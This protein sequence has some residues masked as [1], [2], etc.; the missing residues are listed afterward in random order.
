GRLELLVTDLL[1]R[2]SVP[3]IVCEDSGSG[4]GQR[5]T[6]RL[7]QLGYSNVSILDGGL[8]AW[9]KAGFETYS[10]VNVPSKAFGEF[11]EHE[12]GTPSMS[13]DELQRLIAEG[14]DLVVL[15]SRPFGE[16]NWA[17]IPGG[18]CCPGAELVYRASAAVPSSK[19]RVIVNCA[20]RTRSIIGAQSLINA[21]LPNE[22]YALRNGIMGWRLSGYEPVN[23][24]QA[25]APAPTERDKLDAKKSVTQVAARFAVQSISTRELSQ[26]QQERDSN[27]LFILDVRTI[28]EFDLNHLEGAVH[29]PGGQLVQA[30]DEYIGVRNARIVLVD[31]DATRATMTASWLTQMG[32]PNIRT[33]AIDDNPDLATVSGARTKPVVGLDNDRL[34]MIA[35]AVA[36]ALIDEGALVLDMSLSPT[37]REG[38]IPESWFVLRS[39]LQQCLA[40]IQASTPDFNTV[41]ALILTS[42]E[43][44]LAALGLSELRALTDK[45][46]YTLNGGNAAWQRSGLKLTST[47][48]KYGAE[49]IDIWRI[50]FIADKDKG[51]TV[52]DAMRAY[53]DWE[54]DL[55][56][57]LDRDAT[58][59]FQ[60]FPKA[61]HL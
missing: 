43:G 19:T 56:A 27:S 53:L 38:H 36:E 31:N 40:S 4:L 39:Q 14:S 45:P 47:D 15:D 52:E 26:W 49:P 18:L 34:T 13:A 6:T 32:H 54:V 44:S 30:T 1:P 33:F 21:G 7:G 25:R 2:R 28:E 22:I 48:P 17:S 42:E 23:G 58:I 20:G 51:E 9:A 12:E 16:F 35:P 55:M 37:Y 60:P 41:P 46:I 57:Q 50:P 10:G 29:A 8:E 59:R 61:E 11:V 5:A 3:I 24:A